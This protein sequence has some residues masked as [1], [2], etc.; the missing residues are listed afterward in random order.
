LLLA[1]SAAGAS[2]QARYGA[3][4]RQTL[5]FKEGILPSM[6]IISPAY[7]EEAS[8]VESVSAL[9]T[10]RYP[11][12]E[13]IVVNDGSKDA[14]LQRLVEHFGL[15]RTDV[16]IHRYLNT[17][18]IRGVY[19][20]GKYPEL[21]VIDKANG[22]KADSLNAGL[23]VARKEYFAGI[24]ADSLLEHDAL[25]RLASLFLHHE[26][27]VVAAGGNIF[28]V[29]GCTVSRGALV[30]TRIPRRPLA[31][32]Q[33][34]E[35]L[36]AFMAGRIG[37][38]AVK[39]LLI[40][41]GAFGVFHRRRVIDA[42]GYLTRS[43]HY[44]RD[45]VGEDMELVVRL[46]RGLLESRTPFAVEYG[47]D[48]NCWTEIPE[49]FKVLSR[50]RDRWQR[51]LLDI[52]TFHFRM[53]FSPRYGRTGLIGFPYFLIYEVLGPWFEAEGLLAL[54]VSL[55][56]GA[57]PLPLFLVIFTATILLGL[58]VSIVSMLIAESRRDYFR[59]ADKLRLVL[60][61]VI[62]N[63]GFRQVVNQLRL[64]GFLRLLGNVQGWGVMERRGLGRAR[65]PKGEAA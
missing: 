28:P 27:E 3:L 24:D 6:S 7:N 63:F 36:R 50:Q 52:V 43:E 46:T 33:T 40:I 64:R 17:A 20:S 57:I 25:L 21:L 61:A 9:L 39:S 49:T 45:T 59:M 37:W 51:G 15:E 31:R 35:Y 11:D 54:V 48:A 41:S 62:E 53:I 56:L 23:N 13:V 26:E 38:S 18:Q 19:A 8:I 42:H 14:T 32:F 10:L 16:F 29:N 30:E 1:F 55:I 44:A 12:Y 58:L 5:L 34:V 2:R 65:I 4:R 22:G 60:Y 47:H